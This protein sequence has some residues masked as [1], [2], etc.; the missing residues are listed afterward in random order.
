M[1][2][3]F[4]AGE[5]GVGEEEEGEGEEGAKEGFEIVGEKISMF[6]EEC[7]MDVNTREMVLRVVGMLLESLGDKI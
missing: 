6:V 4:E 2:G 5:E 3:A 1:I 7:V